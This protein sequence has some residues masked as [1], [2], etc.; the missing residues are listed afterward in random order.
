MRECT[1]TLLRQSSLWTI[2]WQGPSEESCRTAPRIV[3]L[4]CRRGKCS[5]P[6]FGAFHS[7]VKVA[8]GVWAGCASQSGEQP[9]GWA[10]PHTMWQLG[11]PRGGKWR[12]GGAAE[13]RCGQVHLGPDDCC[14]IS[15]R[16]RWPGRTRGKCRS[17]HRRR[18]IPNSLTLAEPHL[19]EANV[20]RKY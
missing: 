3:E 14:S 8:P 13:V 15:W 7:S 5:Q 9:N 16:H 1:G 20:H 17:G 6:D 10:G 18:P 19:S 11:I 4:Q 12:R 2:D